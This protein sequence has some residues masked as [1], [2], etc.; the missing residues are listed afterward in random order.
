M[1][2]LESPELSDF[3]AGGTQRKVQG[4]KLRSLL[5]PGP[6]REEV[7]GSVWGFTLP[8]RRPWL[9]RLRIRVRLL[10]SSG[11]GCACELNGEDHVREGASQRFPR[12]S[13]E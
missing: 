7:C 8:L 2:A 6:H 12:A 11:Q 10:V 13:N 5:H 3:A 9:C 1:K 4:T